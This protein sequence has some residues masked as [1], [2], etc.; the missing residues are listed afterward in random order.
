MNGPFDDGVSA[1][2]LAGIHTAYANDAATVAFFGADGIRQVDYE[3][4][5]HPIRAFFLAIVAGQQKAQ[6]VVGGE[7]DLL[8]RVPILVYLPRQ[9]PV[10]ASIAVPPA[11]VITKVSGGALTGTFIYRVTQWNEA[12]ESWA[13]PPVTV[14]LA[15]ENAA[16]SFSSPP[17][18]MGF[19]VWRST[20][21]C[22]ACRYNETIQ[23]ATV[24]SG[25]VDSVPDASLGDELAPVR[26]F[27]VNLKDYLRTVLYQNETLKEA[28]GVDVADACLVLEDKLDAIDRAR[29]LRVIGFA[30][31]AHTIYGTQDGDPKA[32]E[33]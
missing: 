1:R 22:T 26:L 15:G 7:A 18:G 3:E 17:A 20:K 11:P 6:R 21:G 5:E 30:A 12:G 9:T 23:P 14:T 28:T 4:L 33:L 25:Y 2:L 24:P 32:D 27:A 29:N 16:V 13:S 10:N 19:R 31:Q 8:Y